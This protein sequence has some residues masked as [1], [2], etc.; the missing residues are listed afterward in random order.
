MR[1]GK[2]RV[3]VAL[4]HPA[5]VAAAKTSATVG[6]V[7][8]TA[9]STCVSHSRGA[10]TIANMRITEQL[11]PPKRV[12]VACIT[13]NKATIDADVVVLHGANES[14]WI[15]PPSECLVFILLLDPSLCWQ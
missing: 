7:K 13:P 3:A 8:I 15:C 14:S 4:T 11:P 5:K 12:P 2:G 1:S 9:V 10:K 6:R